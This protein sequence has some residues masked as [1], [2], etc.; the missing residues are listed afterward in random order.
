MSNWIKATLLATSLLA[1]SAVIGKDPDNPYTGRDVELGR[2][3]TTE[4]IQAWD[5]DVRPDFSGLPAGSGP[6]SLSR[7]RTAPTRR[8]AKRFMVSIAPPATG[9]SATPIIFSPPWFWAT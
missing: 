6:P 9:I 1:T 7:S 4:E 3:A 2:N 5:I 8:W